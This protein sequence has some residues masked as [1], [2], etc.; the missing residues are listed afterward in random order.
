MRILGS[1]GNHSSAGLLVSFVEPATRAREEETLLL[2][3]SF[4]S[5]LDL[6]KLCVCVSVYVCIHFFDLKTFF[7]TFDVVLGCVHFGVN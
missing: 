7:W 1:E 2:F 4:L 3:L 5:L 6:K